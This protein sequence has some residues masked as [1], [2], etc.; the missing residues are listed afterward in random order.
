MEYVQ[1]RDIGV[2]LYARALF[3]LE[4]CVSQLDLG[5]R[6][7]ATALGTRPFDESDGSKEQRLRE[8][9]EASKHMDDRIKKGQMPGEALSAV[10]ITNSGLECKSRKGKDVTLSFGELE[11]LLAR[12]RRQA[13]HIATLG[14]VTQSL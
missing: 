2:S 12:T 6:L 13:E 5:L 9:Y 7:V 11:E 8:I 4:I 3:N 14:A 10:W 1:R